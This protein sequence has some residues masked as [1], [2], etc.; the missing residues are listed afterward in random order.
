MNAQQLQDQ[1][2]FELAD[3]QNLKS[4]EGEGFTIEEWIE[5]KEDAVRYLKERLKSTKT[6]K[7]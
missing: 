3:L 2:D 1:I 5:V 7:G 4:C 6:T